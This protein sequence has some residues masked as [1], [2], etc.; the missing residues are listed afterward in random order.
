MA[1]RNLHTAL[2]QGDP[3]AKIQN[4]DAVH[5]T[6]SNRKCHGIFLLR[7]YYGYSTFIVLSC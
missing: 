3:P 5:F 4:S 2:A 6:G 7:L 1:S